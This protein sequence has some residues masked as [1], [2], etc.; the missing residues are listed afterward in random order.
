LR[1]SLTHLLVT[2]HRPADALAASLELSGR[3]FFVP[4]WLP[5][6]EC[7]RC[8]RGWVAACERARAV[9]ENGA[10]EVELTERFLFDLDEPT[11][12]APLPEASAACAGVVAE[13]QELGARAGLG[14]GDVA[15]WIG[16]DARTRLGARLSASRGC[17]TF[18]VSAGAPATTG[19][20]SLPSKAPPAR[21]I[22]A[23]AAAAAAAPGGFQERRLFVARAE[24]TLVE[25][26]LALW[27]PGST[28]AF[29]DGAGP[30]SLQPS[31]LASGRM[32]VATG[33]GYHPDLL[34]EAM[35]SLRR[36]PGLIEDLLVEGA[37]PADDR[38]GL[39]RL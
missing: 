22:E 4:G 3:R 9:W 13:L 17:S 34:P 10:R 37:T 5:C 26:A 25:A 21:W 8:R 29:V 19:V 38:L 31:A 11:G 14:S 6:G 23:L 2:G 16:D 35:A 28:L 33:R 12:V 24:S 1:L 27:A 39:V 36:E 32:I 30:A 18:H 20:V 7:G 15:V